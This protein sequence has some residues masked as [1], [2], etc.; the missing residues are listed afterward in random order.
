MNRRLKI[1]FIIGFTLTWNLSFSQTILQELHNDKRIKKDKEM[2]LEI[3]ELFNKVTDSLKTDFNHSDTLFIIR[4]VDIQSRTGYG[5]VW[6]N[7]LKTSYVD[8]KIWK[9]NKIVGSKP[10]IE[11]KTDKTSWSEFDG[12]VP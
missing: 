10:M 3:T 11:T 9:S 6:N 1:G 8:N 7:R 12:L 2:I 5:Y 4:G